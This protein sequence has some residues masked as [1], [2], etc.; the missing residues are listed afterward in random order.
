MRSDVMAYVYAIQDLSVFPFLPRHFRMTR[1]LL[2]PFITAVWTPV[3]L[4]II[5][6]I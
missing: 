3:V 6:I 1:V 2:S 5:N 4:A